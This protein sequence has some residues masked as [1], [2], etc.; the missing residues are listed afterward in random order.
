[1]LTVQAP[2]FDSLPSGPKAEQRE[3][4]K[5]NIKTANSSQPAQDSMMTGGSQENTKYDQLYRDKKGR[6]LS[7]K[8]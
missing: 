6:L 8:G 5:P 1:V 2:D 4:T 7:I 3:V